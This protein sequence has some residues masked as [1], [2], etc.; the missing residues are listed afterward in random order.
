MIKKLFGYQIVRD[1]KFGLKD[2]TKMYSY[3]ENHLT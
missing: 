1:E 3:V 2:N